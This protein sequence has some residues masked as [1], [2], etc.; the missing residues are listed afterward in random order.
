M[1][2]CLDFSNS[3]EL[4]FVIHLICFFPCLILLLFHKFYHCIKI[5]NEIIGVYIDTLKNIDENIWLFIPSRL[6]DFYCNKDEINFGK[7]KDFNLWDINEFNA[8]PWQ[9]HDWKSYCPMTHQV[10]ILT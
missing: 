3:H 4:L 5:L 6:G 1:Y 7:V 9:E 8:P 2:Q 10:K